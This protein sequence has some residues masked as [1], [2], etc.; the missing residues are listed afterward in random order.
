M[1]RRPSLSADLAVAAMVTGAL[2][3]A[4][5]AGMAQSPLPPARPAG[6]GQVPPFAVLARALG[7]NGLVP[8][9]RAAASV[10]AVVLATGAFLFAL[11][12]AWRGTLSVRLIVGLCIVFI[13]LA[14][15]LPL[16]FSRDVY[17]YTIYGR[18]QSLHHANPYLFVPTAFRGDRIFPLVGPAWRETPPVYGPAFTMLSAAITKAFRGD[19][20]DVWAFKVLAGIAGMALVLVVAR[21]AT[22]LWPERAPFAVALVA[23]NPVFL[24]HSVGS[25]HNDVLVGLSVAVALAVLSGSWTRK[26]QRGAGS[27]GGGLGPELVAAGVLTLGMLVKA[28]AVVPLSLVVIA[29]VWQKPRGRRVPA[30]LAHGAVV[31]GLVASFAAPYFQTKDP[32]LGLATLATHVGWLAPLRLFRVTLSKAAG[33]LLGHGA[34]SAVAGGVSVAFA[35][36]F[37]VVFL[38]LAWRTAKLAGRRSAVGDG[39]PLAGAWAEVHG[40][41]WAWGLLLFTLL[42][43]VLLPWYL[44]WLLPVAWLLPRVGRIGVIALSTLLALSEVVAEPLSKNMPVVYSGM[45]LAGHYVLTPALCVVLGWLLLDFRRRIVRGGPLVDPAA[46]AALSVAAAC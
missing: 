40:A 6:V 17:S 13:A 4:A 38:A 22:R 3:I 35:V 10:I 11:R 20:A 30:L 5:V 27:T 39:A 33:S 37:V 9:G 28:T 18:I 2:S 44:V 21:V 45:V 25:G 23:W 8:G 7:L 1:K 12:E 34:S 26:T 36:V 42:A 31:A 24:F 46:L 43:P 15:A 29:S 41:A 19:V 32:T 16:L 14:T